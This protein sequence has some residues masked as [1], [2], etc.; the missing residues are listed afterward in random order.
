MNQ[1]LWIISLLYGIMGILYA[2]IGIRRIVRRNE[3]EI[4]DFVRL[5]Y[6]FTYGFIPCLIYGQESSGQRNLYFF[7]YSSSG[8]QNI[9]AMLCLSVA[10]YGIL[11]LAY[12]SVPKNNRMPQKEVNVSDVDEENTSG[13]L[14]TMGFIALLIGGVSLFLWTRAYGSLSNFILNAARIRSGNG[15]VYNKFAFMK[16]FTRILP[17]SLYALLSGICIGKP[18]KVKK[19]GLLILLS[20]S[21]VANYLYFMASDSRVTILFTGIAVVAIMLRHRKERNISRYLIL[22][23][24][25]SFILLELTMLADVYTSYVKYGKWI[26]NTDGLISNLTKEFRFILSSDMKVMKAWSEGSLH[27]KI[28]DDLINAIVSWI[29]ERFVP[30]EI[31]ETVWRYNTNIYHTGGSGTSPSALVSTGIY[32]IGLLGALIH[33]FILG[34]VTGYTDSRIKRGETAQYG[35]V[36]YGVCVGLFIEM[37]SHNQISTFVG[38]LFPAFLFFVLTKLFSTVTIGGRR[39]LKGS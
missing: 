26:S 7:D 14:I 36:Y 24:I 1:A 30:F 34:L 29:P 27:R 5:M 3:I 37:V 13:N 17:I 4:F 10:A 12:F 20:I 9:V 19:V 38:S 21:L 2:F 8:I 39:I 35:D 16:H 33:P 23:G 18:K 22:A 31:P 28:F 25:V 15:T 11:N 6:A 32:E